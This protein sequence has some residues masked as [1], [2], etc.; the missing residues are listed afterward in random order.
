MK[1]QNFKM[2][3]PSSEGRGQR[4]AVTKPPLALH[5][6]DAREAERVEREETVGN[7]VVSNPKIILLCVFA[8]LGPF[9]YGFDSIAFSLCLSMTPFQYVFLFFLPS[10]CL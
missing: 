6:E 10:C 1:T 4:H 3:N 5:I 2:V 7:A 8:N 9:V